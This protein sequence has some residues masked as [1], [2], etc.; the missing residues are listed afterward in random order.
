MS[1]IL[2]AILLLISIGLLIANYTM[3]A[4]WFMLLIIALELQEISNKK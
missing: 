3:I 2:T 4:I 1:K